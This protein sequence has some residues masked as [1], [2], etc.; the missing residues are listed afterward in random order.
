MQKTLKNSFPIG[1]G[2]LAKASGCS[3][4]TIRYYEKQGLLSEAERTEGGHRKYTED[5][6]RMLMFIR[7]AR[8]LGF[9]Q[10]VRPNR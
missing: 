1:I 7:R 6:Y 4:E 8:K 3:P 10:R 5:Q 9:G 2:Q